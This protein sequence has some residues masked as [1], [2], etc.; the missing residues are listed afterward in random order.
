MTIFHYAS[1]VRAL[2]CIACTV[3]AIPAC[4]APPQAAG[5]HTYNFSPVNQ[6][7]L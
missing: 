1:R 3:A 6:W 2:L 5:S 7:N 4:A